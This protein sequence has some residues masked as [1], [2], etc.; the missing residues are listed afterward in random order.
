[1]IKTN[2]VG[3]EE[4]SWLADFATIV[5]QR[6][7]KELEK[8]LPKETLELLK[9]VW[10][11]Q[12][13]IAG[14]MEQLTKKT[15]SMQMKDRVSMTEMKR[16]RRMVQAG[17]FDQEHHSKR[18][19]QAVA[20]AAT[21]Y[22]AKMRSEKNAVL[23]AHGKELLRLGATDVLYLLPEAT[24]I[25]KAVAMALKGNPGSQPRKEEPSRSNEKYKNLMAREK[26]IELPPDHEGSKPPAG[27]IEMD[28]TSEENT[29]DDCYA[30]WWMQLGGFKA[31]VNTYEHHAHQAHQAPAHWCLVFLVTYAWCSWCA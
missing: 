22:F 8:T 14:E 12:R 24:T 29:W 25:K 1:M 9:K 20:L 23:L 13:K 2:S 17:V 27:T 28:R 15:L 18:R 10:A 30:T 4:L 3:P 26:Y 19:K 11:V 7:L 16:P 5:K 6:N 31:L 21:D